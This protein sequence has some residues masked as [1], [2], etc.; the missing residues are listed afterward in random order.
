MTLSKGGKKRQKKKK[1][2]EKPPLAPHKSETERSGLPPTSNSLNPSTSNDYHPSIS[3]ADPKPFLL[4]K[5]QS[6]ISFLNASKKNFLF[7]LVVED[8]ELLLCA[9]TENVLVVISPFHSKDL[10]TSSLGTL[11][12]NCIQRNCRS[13]IP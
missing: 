9:S 5:F 4:F 1:K 10:I 2:K 13:Q 3:T 7:S 6:P 11:S 12:I 8:L